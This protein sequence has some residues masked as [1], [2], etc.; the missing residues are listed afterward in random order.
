MWIIR[1]AFAIA[2]FPITVTILV[3]ALDLPALRRPVSVGASA[4]SISSTSETSLGCC[5][6]SSRGTVKAQLG[7]AVHERERDCAEASAPVE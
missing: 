4:R 6:G 1:H 2:V 5:H 7:T 3:S